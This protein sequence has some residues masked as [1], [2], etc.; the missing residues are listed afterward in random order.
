[1]QHLVEEEFSWFCAR[2]KSL[3]EIKMRRRLKIVRNT[4]F[5]SRNIGNDHDFG[6]YSL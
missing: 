1:M 2:P 3:V 6:K 4:F 5:K